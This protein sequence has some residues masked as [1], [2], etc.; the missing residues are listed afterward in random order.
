MRQAGTREGAVLLLGSSL[1]IV[2]SVMVAPVLPKMMAAFM[3][4]EPH[5]GLWVPLAITGPALAIALFAPVAGWLADRVGRKP[6]LVAATLLYAIL[7]ALP[8]QLDALMGVV[9]ARLAFGVAEAMVMTGCST[10]IADY[11]HGEQRLRYV[12]RQVVT[13]GLVGALFFVAGGV[14]GESSWRTPFY[15]YLLPLLLVPF[16]LRILWEPPLAQQQA[17]DQARGTDRVDR[18]ALVAGCALIAVGM[19]LCFVVTIQTPVILVG[20]GVTSS[21]LIG[22]CTG[23][24]LLASLLGALL[25][26]LARRGLGLHGCN[27]L[28]L[29]LLAGGLWILAEAPGYASVLLA[30]TVHG[31]G[32]GMLVPNAMAPVMNALTPQ[33]RGRGMGLFTGCLYI[34]Q[35]VSPLVVGLAVSL[36][37]DLRRGILLLVALAVLYAVGWSGVALRG[38]AGL[39][40]SRQDQPPL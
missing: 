34:G 3:P 40:T 35:F 10:L 29:L 6:M 7:G 17:R 31:I 20:L 13:I 30:V 32:A 37:G 12:N 14:L 38:R 15:L 33:T 21:T 18:V 27:G 16:M 9:A 39:A 4:S 8:A 11:W 5:A 25:W 1:T 36:G 2:G 26:P 22:L 23:W 24:A 28:L 19:V